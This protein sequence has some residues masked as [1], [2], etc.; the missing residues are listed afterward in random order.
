MTIFDAPNRDNCT[1]YRERTN[2]PLQA[3]TLLNDPQFVEASRV[4]A[5]R[6]FTSGGKELAGRISYA[7]RL[8]TSRTPSSD[9]VNILVSL[10][11]KEL[12]HFSEAKASAAE[13]LSVGEYP[14][15]KVFDKAELAAM[16]IVA[17]T[18]L[19]HDE[20]YVKR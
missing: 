14:I 1:V 20:A 19:N 12:K 6:A 3:L 10:Y 13:L 18:I 9:E 4:L 11:G 17:N 2:T 7:F 15:D 8:G 5:V 16:T